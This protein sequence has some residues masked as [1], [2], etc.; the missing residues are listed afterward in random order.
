MEKA[1]IIM[2]YEQNCVPMSVLFME[3]PWQYPIKLIT[4]TEPNSKGN[5]LLRIKSTTSL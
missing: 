5:S 3:N 2:I 4:V 1:N